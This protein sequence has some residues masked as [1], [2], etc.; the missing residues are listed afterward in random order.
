MLRG[1]VHDPRARA[2][3]GRR[4]PRRTC[5]HGRRSGDLRP[6]ALERGRR[7][8][9]PPGPLAAGGA[10]DD[11][12]RGDTRGPAPGAGLGRADQLQLAARGPLRRHQLRPYRLHRHQPLD[13]PR[14]R[15]IRRHPDQPPASRRPCSVPDLASHR[16]RHAGR[17]RDR[18]RS[19][20][21]GSLCSG[22]CRRA[23][24]PCPVE[25]SPRTSVSITSVRHRR[26]GRGALSAAF[27]GSRS[28]W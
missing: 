12:R 4:R 10:G 8:Q 3:G 7:A 23:R 2:L 15:D 14:D 26:P 9:R 19:L 28:A 5:S 21:A 22:A 13:R 16:G 11:R 17:R 1:V 27:A 25:T 18:R 20:A 6:D 24:G